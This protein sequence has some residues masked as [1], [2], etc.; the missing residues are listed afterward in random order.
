MIIDI[1]KT[2]RLKTDDLQWHLQRRSAARSASKRAGEWKSVAYA[3]DVSTLLL[4]AT[5]RQIFALVGEYPPTAIEPLCEA[6]T[7]IRAD[8]KRAI[9]QLGPISIFEKMDGL[10]EMKA[11]QRID[12]V[13]QVK[14]RYRHAKVS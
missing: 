5:R 4:E 1:N 13:T 9:G 14:A 6:L 2:W 8:I 11:N 10:V 12:E 3:R 7:E